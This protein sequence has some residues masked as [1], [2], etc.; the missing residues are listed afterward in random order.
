MLFILVGIFYYP[1]QIH[2]SPIRINV[3]VYVARN[4][5][6]VE[7]PFNNEQFIEAQTPKTVDW[8]VFQAARVMQLNISQTFIPLVT[9]FRLTVIQNGYNIRSFD[10]LL[11]LS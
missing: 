11:L 3:S 4:S 6:T 10:S 7:G 5:D 9:G 8:E 1:L 2:Q